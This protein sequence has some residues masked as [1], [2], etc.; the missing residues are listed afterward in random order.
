MSGSQNNMAD[1]PLVSH[2]QPILETIHLGFTVKGKPLVKDVNIK[3]YRGDVLAIVGQSGSGKTSFLRILNRLDEPT[4]GTVLL[5]GVD[6][7]QIPPRELRRRIGLVMQTPFLFPGTVAFNLAYGP[8]QRGITLSREDIDSL[9]KMV[10]LPG[11]ADR[12]IGK[13]SGGEAQRVQLA[14]TLSNSPEIL[15]LDEPTSALDEASKAGIES[16]ILRIIKEKHLTCLIVTHDLRQV[17][18]MATRIMKMKNGQIVQFG[19]IEE[20]LNGDSL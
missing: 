2:T 10:G 20:V 17:E 3:V 19:S 18:R 15:L 13:L 14:R 1:N 8:A 12:D 4:S 5:E 9:L 16:L 6:Y 7:R 11:Y